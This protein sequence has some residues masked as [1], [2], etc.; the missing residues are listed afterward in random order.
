M[1]PRAGCFLQGTAAL[2]GPSKARHPVQ[3]PRPLPVQK[4]PPQLSILNS[5][6]YS[7]ELIQREKASR[8]KVRS[9]SG[10]SVSPAPPK[11]QPPHRGPPEVMRDTCSELLELP[12]L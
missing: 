1:A 4:G 11:G 5:R 2:A 9:E 6:P 8:Q 10:G 3:V 7:Q 12:I